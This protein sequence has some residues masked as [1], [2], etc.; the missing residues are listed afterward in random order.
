MNNIYNTVLHGWPGLPEARAQVL[1]KK[2]F[3]IHFAMTVKW[4]SEK[5]AH[6]PNHALNHFLASKLLWMF[7][8]VVKMLTSHWF[9]IVL[10]QVD[11]VPQSWVELFHHILVEWRQKQFINNF[12]HIFFFSFNLWSLFIT[13]SNKEGEKKNISL[14]HFRSTTKICSSFKY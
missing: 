7:I 3:K 10:A 14:F 1:C 2:F 13:S 11:Q 5:D 6:S 9:L 8:N 4:T 12:S